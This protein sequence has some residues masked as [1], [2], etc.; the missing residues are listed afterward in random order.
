MRDCL[1]TCAAA[2]KG[3]VSAAVRRFIPRKGRTR[4]TYMEAG[5]I[6]Q[7]NGSNNK[8]VATVRFQFVRCAR[9][10]GLVKI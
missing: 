6:K 5:E 7:T 1:T 2:R 9:R 10:D 8:I 4:T 3:A